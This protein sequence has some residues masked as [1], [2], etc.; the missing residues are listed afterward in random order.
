MTDPRPPRF[1]VIGEALIDLV[2]TG[3]SPYAAH[4]GGSPLNVAIGLSRLGQR[5]AFLGRFSRDPFGA[6]LRRHAARSNVDL[7]LAVAA[8][9]P[10]TVAL[11]ELDEGAAHYTFSIDGTADFQ[12]TDAEL[13]KL[14]T[15]VEAVHFGSLASWLPPG[16]RAIGRWIAQLHAAGTVLLSYD[17]NVRPALQPDP[18]LARRSVEAALAQ[19][20]V[21]KASE[22]D[23]R[24][25]YGD[26]ALGDTALGDIAARWL[27]MGPHLVVVTRGGAGAVAFVGGCDPLTRPV[28]AAPVIDTVGAGDAFMSGLLDGLARRELTAPSRLQAAVCRP[29]TLAAVLDEAALVAALTCSRAG[30]APP[31]A[32]ELDAP[33]G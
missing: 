17:P 29:S 24:W 22:D 23:L 19:A 31:W 6:V 28:H 21:V 14:P 7:S 2:D 3:G 15:S 18:A 1:T 20:H 32:D 10:S 26:A 13:A 5:T 11:V 30:A 12:W 27:A 4:A 33:R 25:L 8:A 9:E 16:D